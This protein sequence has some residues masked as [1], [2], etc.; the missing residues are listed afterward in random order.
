MTSLLLLLSL[1]S[2]LAADPTTPNPATAPAGS[3]IPV[4]R[5]GG[6][7]SLSSQTMAV[8][9]WCAPV[10]EPK[11]KYVAENPG[12]N[13]EAESQA[14]LAALTERSDVDVLV[15][16][17]NPSAT[18]ITAWFT[19]F[20]AKLG[21]KGGIY[22]DLT[23]SVS[24]LV[25]DGDMDSGKLHTRDA[26]GGSGGLAFADLAVAASRLSAQSLWLLDT[27]RDQRAVISGETYGET[28]DDITKFDLPNAIAIS[29]GAPG[30][31]ADGG[32]VGAAAQVIRDTKGGALTFGKLYYTGVKQRVPQLDLYTSLGL[33][34]GDVWTAE[35]TVFVGG[36]LIVAPTVTL[37]TEPLVTSKKKIPTGCYVAGAGVLAL[38]GSSVSA[39]D[40][41][42]TYNTLV[43]YNNE[44]GETQEELDT[45][46]NEYRTGLI[47][48]IGLGA[49]GA[50]ALIGG[51]TWTIIDLGN[52]KVEI[53]PTGNGVE[54][55]GKF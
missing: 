53:T 41:N 54:V 42:S 23:V 22:R 32:L 11:W 33:V 1:P 47:T 31:Y 24:C 45:A 46:V 34:P 13:Y 16:M 30:K 40:T 39:V 29:T 10:S 9:L 25:T 49:L 3:H 5:P 48:S 44:G 6:A 51:T 52:A 14:M 18:E 55:H 37:P 2:A 26:V 8:V 17:D 19:D 36:P 35:R 4:I 20:T 7:E 38:I 50:A 21:N 27:S 28:A 12:A 43:L 15:F